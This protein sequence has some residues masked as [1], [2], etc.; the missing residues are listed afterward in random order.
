MC[1]K[2]VLS[3]NADFEAQMSSFSNICVLEFSFVLSV[4]ACEPKTHVTGKVINILRDVC[5][6]FM[7]ESFHAILHL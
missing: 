5:L 7:L 2:N 1:L 3:I 6:L 4:N